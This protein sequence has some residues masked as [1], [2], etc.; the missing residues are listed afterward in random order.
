M[1]FKTFIEVTCQP[2]FALERIFPTKYQVCACFEPACRWRLVEE[3]GADSFT[4]QPDG[5]LLFR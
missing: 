4:V 1:K 3:Y 2:D 5:R